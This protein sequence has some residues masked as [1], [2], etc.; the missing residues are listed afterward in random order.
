MDESSD[1]DEPESLQ[2]KV[3]LLGDG[4]VGKTSIAMR[5]TDDEFHKRHVVAERCCHRSTSTFLT[6]FVSCSYKQTIGV[7]FFIKRLS[8]PA[9]V[10]VAVQV[11]QHIV[12]SSRHTALLTPESS[13]CVALGHWW[14]DNRREDDRQLH[15]RLAR[16]APRLRHHQ[17]SGSC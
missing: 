3:I 9:N 12:W 6:L 17:L 2:Y 14:T 7:D 10:N 5:F 1:D 16:G 13:P 15:I 4:T 8:L 11:R